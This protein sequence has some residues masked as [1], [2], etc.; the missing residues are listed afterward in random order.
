M[1]NAAQGGFDAADDDRYAGKGFAAAL[2]VDRGAAVGAQFDLST[3]RVG[4]LV[5]PFLVRRVVVDHGV[6][7][8]AADRVE[9]AWLAHGAPGVGV[10]PGWLAEQGHLVAFSLEG[11]A[12]QGV[13]EGRVVHVGVA[14]NEDDVG[15]VPAQVAD[16]L[17]GDGQEV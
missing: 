11:A 9:K 8:A 7:V 12:E 14:G 6:H 3:G 17:W 10:L 15:L 1:R 2:G 16:L 5:A 4:V 13:G